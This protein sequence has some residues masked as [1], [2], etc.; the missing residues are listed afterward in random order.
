MENLALICTTPASFRQRQL[1]CVRLHGNDAV[2]G[3]TCFLKTAA[4]NSLQMN[5]MT[6]SGSAS[7]ALLAV[8]RSASCLPTLNPA[9][10]SPCLGMCK[11]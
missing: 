1:I 11:Q 9:C 7:R 10:Q 8:Y 3:H 4:Q 6:S 5:L 2:L